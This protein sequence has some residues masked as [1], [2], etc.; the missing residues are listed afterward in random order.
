MEVE[1]EREGNWGRLKLQKLQLQGPSW[2]PC[3]GHHFT[4]AM[5][6]WDTPHPMLMLPHQ[7]RPS[8]VKDSS[9]GRLSPATC[10]WQAHTRKLQGRC[11]S[12]LANQPTPWAQHRN[13]GT[14]T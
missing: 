2:V 13:A 9:R 12:L 1:G 8:S 7:S 6:F 5:T 14:H 3:F 4:L 11:L 10:H